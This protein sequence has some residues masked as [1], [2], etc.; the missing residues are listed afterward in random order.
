[1]KEA[2]RPISKDDVQAYRFYLY[3]MTFLLATPSDF[4][5]NAQNGEQSIIN[6]L[7]ASGITDP[8]II[9]A[10]TSFAV[11][12]LQD[13]VLFNLLQTVH[14]ALQTR[15]GKASA[16]PLYDKVSCPNG[17]D[18]NAIMSALANIPA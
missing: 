13:P 9:T 17:L 7:K 6:W 11:G 1:M 10:C 14:A 5:S 2:L 16:V 15:F 12:T 18:S 8:K 3:A 4:F